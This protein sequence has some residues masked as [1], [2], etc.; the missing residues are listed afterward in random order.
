MLLNVPRS[1]A[2]YVVLHELAHFL[3]PNHSRSF[4]DFIAGYMPDWQER[5]RLLKQID[6]EAAAVNR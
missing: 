4:Y 3:Y 2:E 1:C 5:E 6:R